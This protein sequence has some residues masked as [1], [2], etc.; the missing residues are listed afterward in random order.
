MTKWL[1]WTDGSSVFGFLVWFFSFGFLVLHL[2]LHS[3]F[4]SGCA[5]LHSYQYYTNVPFSQ[6]SLAVQWSRLC[7]YIAGGMN[8]TY[9]QGESHMLYGEI[10]KKK[11]FPFLYTFANICYLDTFWR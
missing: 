10:K 1:N 6:T 7:N 2:V 9:G 3:V 4:R 11:M 8:L 5:N